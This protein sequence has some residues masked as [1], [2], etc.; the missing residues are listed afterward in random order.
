MKS[1][2][3]MK[4]KIKSVIF[5]FFCLSLALFN[6]WVIRAWAD[7]E[8]GVTYIV[9]IEFYQSN[10]WD[11]TV[12]KG[13]AS[14]MRVQMQ[15]NAL[16]KKTEDGKYEV[17]V[18]YHGSSFED[19]LQIMD[20]SRLP[21]LKELYKSPDRVPMGTFNAPEE[22]RNPEY[23]ETLKNTGKID[24]EMDPYYRKDITFALVDK[25]MDIGKMV[26]TMDRLSDGAY[27][28][29]CYTPGKANSIG[30]QC[31]RF[32][33]EKKEIPLTYNEGSYRLGY[34]WYNYGEVK[35]TDYSRKYTEQSVAMYEKLSD[36]FEKT[37]PVSVEGDGK[38][39]A[40]FK[41]KDSG[42]I[43]TIEIATKKNVDFNTLTSTQKTSLQQE[44]VAT[45][46]ETVWNSDTGGETIELDFNDI[47]DGY[48]LRI[49]TNELEAYNADKTE[50]NQKGW[51]ACLKLESAP[52][53]ETEDLILTSGAARL[54]AR[55]DAVPAD[56]EFIFRQLSPEETPENVIKYTVDGLRRFSK[57]E[58]SCLVYDGSLESGGTRV[59]KL[60]GNVTLEVALPEG[61][62]MD[63]TAV[64]AFTSDGRSLLN[65]MNQYIDKETRTFRYTTTQSSE[66]N[67]TYV[68]FDR[69]NVLDP[70][71]MEQLEEGV[72]EVDLTIA[73]ATYRFR[74]SMAN[75]SIMDNKG[76]LE[77]RAG[78]DGKKTYQLYYGM[79]PVYVG[80]IIGYMTG[81]AYC[82]GSNRTDITPVT[83]L[84]Y[85]AKEDGNLDYDA[86]AEEFHFQYLKRLTFPL[87]SPQEDGTYLLQ[88]A[89]PAMDAELG[90]GS[91]IQYAALRVRNPQKTGKNQLAGYE[92]SVLQAVIDRAGRYLETL[93]S[94]SV[95]YNI[96]KEAIDAARE[97]NN[98]PDEETIVSETEKLQAALKA[99]GGDSEGVKLSDGTY[100]LSFEIQNSSQSGESDFQKYFD[101]SKMELKI[102]DG[103]MTLTLKGVKQGEDYVTSFQYDNGG[104]EAEDGVI[105]NGEDGLPVSYAFTRAYT[106]DPIEIKLRSV[107]QNAFDYVCYLTMDISGAAR[108]KATEEE[109]NA[110]SNKVLEA[111]KLLE[112]DYTRN[113]YEALK[114]A[115]EKAETYLTVEEPSYDIISGQTAALAGAFHDLVSLVDLK[116]KIKEAS[117]YKSSGYTEESY[118]ALALELA[119]AR[120]ILVKADAS[121]EEVSVRTS[122]LQE[123][124]QDL[125]PAGE[126]PGE[127]GLEDGTYEIPMGLYNTGTENVHMDSPYYRSAELTVS[128]AGS[129]MGVKLNMQANGESWIT[130]LKYSTDGGETKTEV[131][132]MEKD[133]AGNI[134]AFRL[135]LPYTEERI[136]LY[137]RSTAKPYYDT[138]SDLVLDFAGA[139]KKQE[140]E[141]P[142]ADKSKLESLLSE[143]ESI[144]KDPYTTDSYEKLEEARSG[145]NVVNSDQNATQTEVDD[146][147]KSLQEAYD[148]LESR[149]DL[150]YVNE[151]ISKA[152]LATGEDQ[153]K[154]TAESVQALKE[155]LDRVK[156]KLEADSHNMNQEQVDRQKELLEDA[157]GALEESRIP[158]LKELILSCENYL[159]EDYTE[160][161][162]AALEAALK[163]ARN[164]EEEESTSEEE[165]QDAIARLTMA[166]QALEEK[167]ETEDLSGILLTLQ[168]LA[169][170]MTGEVQDSADEMEP[171]SYAAYMASV[172]MADSSNSYALTKDQIQAQIDWMNAESHALVRNNELEESYNVMFFDELFDAELP[173]EELI[174]EKAVNEELQEEQKAETKAVGNIE[175]EPEAETGK[176]PI[177]ETEEE[178]E[179]ETKES[180]EAET[181]ESAEAETEESTEPETEKE[182]ETD[183]EEEKE[184]DGTPQLSISRSTLSMFRLGESA[185]TPSSA[186]QDK[187][188]Q[189]SAAL[190]A[191]KA[192]STL[193]RD[194][195]YSINYALWKYDLNAASMGNP[196]F[197]KPGTLIIDDGK[198]S[199]YMKMQGMNY[200]GLYGHLK[201]IYFMKNIK[202][203]SDGL[204]YTTQAPSYIK[205][206]QESDDYGPAGSYP[207]VAGFPV[208]LYQEY[209]P[210]EVD[211]PVMGEVG[212]TQVARL[213]LYWDSLTYVN[214]STDYEN[215]QTEEPGGKEIDTEDLKKAVT[216][217]ETM[218]KDSSKFISKSYY[219]VLKS[220]A[221]GE[222]LLDQP[223]VS[224]EM[225]DNRAAAIRAGMN[226]LI[227]AAAS[228]EKA[229]LKTLIEKAEAEYKISDYTEA[230]YKV[231]TAAIITAEKT[232]S[233]TDVTPGMVNR[234]M[235][236][237]NMAIRQL[238]KDTSDDVKRSEL[239]QWITTAKEYIKS[240]E[241]TAA[242]KAALVEVLY[243]AMMVAG[244]EK[245]T[246]REVDDQTSAIK[247]AVSR[248]EGTVDK[249]EL[250]ELLEKTKKYNKSD[251]TE[252]SY[253]E[254]VNAVA[255][256]T[257][258]YKDQTATASTVREASNAIKRAINGLS[259]AD[260]G[261]Q[262]GGLET[263]NHT[264][265]SW[266][267]MAG[268]YGSN[269]Y[270]AS[271]YQTLAV[272]LSSAREVYASSTASAAE[273]LA[274]AGILQTAVNNLV[275]DSDSGSSG[276]SGKS[277]EDDGCYKVNVCLWH[278]TMNK[279]SMGDGA[280]EKKAY[281]QIEDGDVNMRLVTKKMTVS[282]ITAHLHD[283]W[284]YDGG[285]YE[286]ADLVS[287]E[288]S[289]WIFEFNLPND[290]SQYYKCKVDPQV[291]VM[292]D[293]PVKARLKVDWSSLKE[294]DEDDW[295]ELTGDVDDDDDDTTTIGSGSGSAELIS[296]ETGIRVKGNAG[297]PGV[298]VEV[299]KKDSGADY[300]K[301]IN[302]LSST[303]GRFVLYDIKLKS[304]TEYVQP[305]E[306]VTLRIPV[307]AGYDTG[308]LVLYRIN[309]DGEREEISGRLNGSYFEAN[310][311]HFSLYALAES[312]QAP[313]LAKAADS[314]EGKKTIALSKAGSTGKTGSGAGPKTGRDTETVQGGTGKS[315]E[316]MA[317]GRVIPYTGDRT[318]VKELMGVGTLALLLGFGMAFTGKD[319][320]KRK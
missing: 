240:D 119:N 35:S 305:R 155:V 203:T 313:A 270:T 28:K 6:T 179:A 123:A 19:M 18:F 180:T 269:G 110:L 109:I 105:V 177:A 202:E 238:V 210:V 286:T 222:T 284:I 20:N 43:H 14:N 7:Y 212:R 33:E 247:A 114:G 122:R 265:L 266:I 310:V 118:Q 3:L 303:A 245:A 252:A 251:Y 164:L 200:S 242:S 278:A 224:Q 226:A 311:N 13:V 120:N 211:V 282:G 82:K 160:E 61:F 49:M 213:R 75:S 45:E 16:V 65:Q 317:A 90:D 162:W 91:G 116:A 55:S 320:E 126:E 189:A 301:A 196:S 309:D 292:G 223:G 229:E 99:V 285:D 217:F 115:I 304:G 204:D 52:G 93:E 174:E 209:T 84:E 193:P 137:A 141:V 38:I 46:Y 42:D 136:T 104:A 44:F 253:D 21:E 185:S 145:A 201:S 276:G 290:S 29:N 289:K 30:T 273:R 167:D 94:G 281:V 171:T 70:L 5:L 230:S 11:S 268:S 134:T 306:S 184:K 131:T 279:A 190:A 254:L 133:E 159:Q 48:Y 246:Q 4:G 54:K 10:E 128:E 64:A 132:D 249:K 143:T 283:F 63:T 275:T 208:T 74:P 156:E 32:V 199:I 182:T 257:F 227:P 31:V 295:D 9:P 250:Y 168:E 58:D 50:T 140:P 79:E 76:V 235:K 170:K 139:V 80:P 103:R 302:A 308:R 172:N 26:F 175:E 148:A 244:K 312:N 296:S 151:I 108:K 53:E 152:E 214:S 102:Q 294:V 318:P 262:T 237:V 297:G 154:Y 88:F 163:A 259:A 264:L 89:V 166:I 106:E 78:E 36:L 195:T 198:A 255:A 59:E 24:P 158:E 27:V 225:A 231:L 129:Q 258:V 68:F 274:A 8:T 233:S 71:E 23:V 169:D 57:D 56:S 34:G 314:L 125:V 127:S 218:T 112:E 186:K 316:Q 272:A 107:T 147:V 96:L 67:A 187:K 197:I 232:V 40:E 234:D 111:R 2:C 66:I 228:G 149:G 205:Y 73:H 219:A 220:V 60:N 37:V 293:D 41:I 300:D 47:L 191:S 260:G 277:D 287:T 81:E 291:D 77:V 263:A 178:S 153:G 298:T 319:P 236:M 157:Y 17:T 248:L 1:K 92:K 72:Y 307:P 150:T 243:D 86:W 69:G 280:V 241:Y 215:S 176:E 39:K 15:D 256:G 83:V 161:S 101:T 146:C 207:S 144:S 135:S 124:I 206:S 25:N 100:E 192:V 299:S 173:E 98:N 138:K 315:S 165:C 216:E 51:Y 130:V 288:N 261:G 113:S 142:V 62:H 239:E 121:G 95:A 12:L 188:K 87:E 194:G 97:S 183:M 267:Q 181:E 117:E 271:S 22:Y 221:A 85:Y